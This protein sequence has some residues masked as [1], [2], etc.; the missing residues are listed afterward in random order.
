MNVT[1]ILTVEQVK[2]IQK[3][4]NT[5]LVNSCL[6][7]K[8][9]KKNVE[10]FFHTGN[11][12]SSDGKTNNYYYLPCEITGTLILNDTTFSYSINAGSTG[13]LI[14]NGKHYAYYGCSSSSCEE[15]ILMMPD[16]MNPH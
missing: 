2:L 1:A 4:N 3:E 16:N 14:Y 6:N 7:W 10:D 5:D 15:F 13:E 8:L 9:S 12:I 11:R